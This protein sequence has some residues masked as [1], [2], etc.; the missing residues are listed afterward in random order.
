MFTI[1]QIS[2]AH[3]KVKSGVEKC[4]VTLNSMTC[5]YYDKHGNELLVEMIPH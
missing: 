5:S 2:N 3:S 4:V 1:E